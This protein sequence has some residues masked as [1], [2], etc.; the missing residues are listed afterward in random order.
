MEK[1]HIIMLS[2]Q[3]S[4][5]LREAAEKQGTTQTALVE[6]C[7]NGPLNGIIP[8]EDIKA[9]VIPGRCGSRL[10]HDSSGKYVTLQI[11]FNVGF[12]ASLEDIIRLGMEELAQ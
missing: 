10:H 11:S 4:K 5:G 8:K 9:R 1:M 12:R 3:L 7:L 2:P 6:K